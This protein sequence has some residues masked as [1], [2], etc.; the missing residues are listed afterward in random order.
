[1][2]KGIIFD[3]DGTLLNTLVDLQNATNY[4]LDK[5]N[6]PRITLEMTRN[7]VGNGN[8]KLL[9]RAFK[10]E[11]AEIIDKAF[12]DFKYFYDIHKS[13]NTI[14]Y[15]G[16]MNMI[17]NI[18]NL[19]IKMAIVTNK[20]QEAATSL[21]KPLFGKYIDIIV[22]KDDNIPAKPDPTMA[23]VALSKLNLKPNE[24]I[25]V[26]DSDVD[27]M[28]GKNTKVSKVVGVTWGFKDKEVLEALG[29]DYLID[30]PNQL[31]NIIKGEINNG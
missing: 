12:I 10:T 29:V 15:D 31:I 17:K 26:G 22:G 8:V 11:K 30:K 4:A 7:Y 18:Y 3:L 21:C 28:T 9:E 5:Q 2:L 16:I 27:V 23:N 13:D 25:F 1:M 14:P 20:Y 6:Y 19:G 24:C